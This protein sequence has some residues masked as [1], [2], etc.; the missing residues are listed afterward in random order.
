[1]VEVD[2]E[3][4][5]GSGI[6]MRVHF[7]PSII[8]HEHMHKVAQIWCVP[9]TPFPVALPAHNSARNPSSLRFASPGARAETNTGPW[10]HSG[11]GHVVSWHQEE[12]PRSV[13]DS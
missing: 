7:S 13:A 2:L 4:A 5:A 10:N 12:S 3:K 9:A 11:S 1:M 6:S 8:Q